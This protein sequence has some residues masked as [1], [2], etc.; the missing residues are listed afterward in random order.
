MV[1]L[2]RDYFLDPAQMDLRLFHWL[3][4]GLALDQF[5]DRSA[6]FRQSSDKSRRRC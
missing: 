1:S 5:G 2:I 4:F 6:S 3:G